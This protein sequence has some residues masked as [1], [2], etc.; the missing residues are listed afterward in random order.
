MTDARDMIVISGLLGLSMLALSA[1]PANAGATKVWEAKGFDGP[2][3]ALFDADRNVLYI[4]NVNG[5]PVE[6]DGN[7]YISKISP[8][9]EV[10][11]AK[12]ATGLDA[13]KGLGL[14]GD[15]LYV[16]DINQLVEIDVESGQVLKRHTAP[17]AKFLNDVT[18]D[19]NGR[20]Y[21]SDML[22]NAV[23][24]LDGQ[25]LSLWLQDEALTSPNGLHVEG[26]RLLI[27]AWGV[28]TEGF[29]TEKL[30]NLVC[31]I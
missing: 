23:Y 28:R 19:D 15:R 20:V 11:A 7:G 18:V 6:K 24:L 13:P 2:E 9:G 21:V 14:H 31:P 12:W 3:S 29:A 5:S 1:L 22:D 30:G 8:T 27:A 10:I 4:S 17:A 16:S 25:T 26:D